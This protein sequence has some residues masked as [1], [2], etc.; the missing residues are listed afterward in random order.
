MEGKIILEGITLDEFMESIRVI[1]RQE[2]KQVESE[3]L[4]GISKEQARKQLGGIHFNTLTSL[5]EREGIIEWN[6]A[7]I[8]TI[9]LKYPKYNN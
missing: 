3:K 8:D 1:V 7:L 5:M 4:K 9:K 2:L 6:Q